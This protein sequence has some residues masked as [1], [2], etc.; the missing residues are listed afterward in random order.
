[1]VYQELVLLTFSSQEEI[2]IEVEY[3]RETI[4]AMGSFN[5]K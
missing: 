4:T 2:E 1:M 5:N 3:T